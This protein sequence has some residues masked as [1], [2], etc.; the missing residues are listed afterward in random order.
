MHELKYLLLKSERVLEERA[1]TKVSGDSESHEMDHF[2]KQF[3]AQ[4]RSHL[5][6]RKIH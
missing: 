6:R 5:W 2:Q 4:T 3:E 1:L